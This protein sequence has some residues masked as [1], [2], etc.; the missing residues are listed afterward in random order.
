[1]TASKAKKELGW[2]PVYDSLAALRATL[3][4]SD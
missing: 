4:A 2:R 3:P 1:M